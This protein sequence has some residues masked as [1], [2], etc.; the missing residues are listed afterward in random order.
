MMRTHWN[1]CRR[2][3]GFTRVECVAVL[4]AIGA[5]AGMA[6]AMIA[7]PRGVMTQTTC[8]YNLGQVQ[9][10]LWQYVADND[11][12]F[13]VSIDD[14]TGMRGSLWSEAAWYIPK[15]NLWFYKLAPAY[16]SPT[17]LICPQD[18]FG[19]LFDFDAELDG[20][21]HANTNV[22]SCGYAM[23]YLLRHIAPPYPDTQSLMNTEAIPPRTP[24]ATILL[25]EV[26]PDDAL[27]YAELL[28]P[29]TGTSN[30]GQ[31]WRDGG[32][33]T[34]DDGQRSWYDGPTWLTTRHGKGINVGVYDGS[35][36]RVNAA[37]ALSQGPLSR[38]DAC[39][40]LVP[41]T[42]AYTCLLC[43]EDIPHYQFYDEGLWWWTGVNPSAASAIGDAAQ[44]PAILPH[45]VQ[46][47][48]R[49]TNARPNASESAH[50]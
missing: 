17:Q 33:I 5:F 32:R 22:P 1:R 2:L 6:W 27:E 24:S 20:V 15:Q 44:P 18:P 14:A 41:Q 40:Q 23:N 10:A 4:T 38:T 21:P 47:A 13:P 9:V 37:R 48:H 49:V 50:K 30:T 28:A 34:W 19:D 16:V 46:P 3:R 43:D 35:V 11:G 25:A 42:G 7:L 39:Y 31:P 12:W 8:A 26:G 29:A 45:T 36:R